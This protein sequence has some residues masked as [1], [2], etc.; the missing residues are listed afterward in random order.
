VTSDT[1]IFAD[2][3]VIHANSEVELQMAT[4]QLSNKMAA[5]NLDIQCDKTKNMTFHIKYQ[6]GSNTLLKSI[7]QIQNFNY[8]W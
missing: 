7:E 8:L 6:I 3:Q 5:Y 2:D 1:L 4:L